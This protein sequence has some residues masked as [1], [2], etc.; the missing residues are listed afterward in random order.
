MKI[1]LEAFKKKAQEVKKEE[2]LKVI[3]GGSG[4]SG[5]SLEY[6]HSMCISI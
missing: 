4:G 2:L 6:C 5:A 1:T 3:I